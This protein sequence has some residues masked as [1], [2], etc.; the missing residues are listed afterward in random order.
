MYVSAL[1]R[2]H[3]LKM[4]RLGMKGINHALNARPPP[5]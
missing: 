4:T 3:R 1:V 2:S 5:L